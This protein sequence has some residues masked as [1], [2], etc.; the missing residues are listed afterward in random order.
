MGQSVPHEY[1]EDISLQ[2]LDCCPVAENKR[3]RCHT[4]KSGRQ[5]QEAGRNQ[6]G[7]CHAQSTV[8]PK[9]YRP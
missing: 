3:S 4:A 8:N 7:S 5:T 2:M 9:D 1:R 6:F